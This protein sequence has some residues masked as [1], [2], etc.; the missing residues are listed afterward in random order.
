VVRQSRS[1]AIDD[2]D[3]DQ[4]RAEYPGEQSRYAFLVA[5]ILEVGSHTYY[6]IRIYV[7]ARGS[8]QPGRCEEEK[9][10]REVAQEQKMTARR[11]IWQVEKI[12][13]DGKSALLNTAVVDGLVD[14]KVSA[15]RAILR[16]N[17]F[18]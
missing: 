18:G 6:I 13:S 12:A 14:F 4:S 3:G 2:S 17:S 16:V 15:A 8:R 5:R 10:K 7:C 11:V 9:R 1:V